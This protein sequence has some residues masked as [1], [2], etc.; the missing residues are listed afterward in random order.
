MTQLENHFTENAELD[1][2][3]VREITSYLTDNAADASDYSLS[4]GINSSLRDHEIPLRM[5]TLRYF[6]RI[7]YELPTSM[8]VNNPKVRSLSHC[9]ACHAQAKQ[10]V[11]DENQVRI[12]GYTFWDD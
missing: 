1:A 5:S 8:V 3:D 9:D 2:L 7:H 6:K 11:Y 10:G 12:P 4:R